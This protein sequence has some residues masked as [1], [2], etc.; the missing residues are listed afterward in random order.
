MKRA[1]LIIPFAIILLLLT[2]CATTG[3]EQA[4]KL[5]TKYDI[6]LTKVSRGGD[7]T[8]R[9]KAPVADT[10]LV[11]K[12]RYHY[13][14]EFMHTIW[15]ASENG[16]E[17]TLYNAS[18]KNIILDWEKGLYLDYDNIGHR[19]LI[20][21][22]PDSEKD[23]PQS[24]STIPPRSNITE[25]IYS[26]DH[27]NPSTLL[28]VY[29]RTPLLPTEYK[30]AVRFNGKEMKIQLPVRIDNTTYNYEFTF[31]IVGVRQEQAKSNLLFG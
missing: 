10:T 25:I 2:S 21:S 20:S 23:K 29:V 3:E 5:V 19:L 31:K 15:Y 8:T 28:G 4:T 30:K 14:D 7:E 17:L 16:F 13:D 27:T 26:A 12:L 18:D 24:P 1:Y 11:D 22:T 9:S 6:A